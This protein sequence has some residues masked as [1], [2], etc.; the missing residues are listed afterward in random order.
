MDFSQIES[1]TSV[2]TVLFIKNWRQLEQLQTFLQ[3]IETIIKF[4]FL[5]NFNEKD[6]KDR[7]LWGNKNN[8][9]V[10]SSC[11][12]IYVPILLSPTKKS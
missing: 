1:Q 5:I 4:Q 2:N 12:Y 8:N 11:R 10:F 6:F 7:A 3:K 9:V